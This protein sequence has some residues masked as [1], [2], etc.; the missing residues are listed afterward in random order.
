MNL[1]LIKN[2]CEWEYNIVN[3]QIYKFGR[4][5]NDISWYIVYWNRIMKISFY[6][7][8]Y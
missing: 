6:F 8:L 1:E 2:L 5:I 3:K 4:L 7:V